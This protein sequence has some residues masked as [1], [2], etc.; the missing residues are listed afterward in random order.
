VEVDIA[1]YGDYRRRRLT[2]PEVRAAVRAVVADG[3]AAALDA[4]RALL[5]RLLARMPG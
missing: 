5:A 3:L 1:R 4:D 2:M